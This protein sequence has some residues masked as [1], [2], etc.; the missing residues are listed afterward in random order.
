MDCGEHAALSREAAP[1]ATAIGAD[2]QGAIL[3]LGKG[4]GRP[5]AGPFG[6]W[7]P[8]AIP[9]LDNLSPGAREHSAVLR[10]VEC[11]HPGPAEI[12]DSKRG[13]THPGH[14]TR[15]QLIGGS[16]EV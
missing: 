11:V 12:R 6:D 2:P 5:P 4:S 7:R 13:A 8:S 16:T 14:D 15:P 1:H 3:G 10:P 9:A